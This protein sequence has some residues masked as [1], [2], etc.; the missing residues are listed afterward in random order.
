LIFFDLLF[1]KKSSKWKIGKEDRQG[2]H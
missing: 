1:Y 2:G